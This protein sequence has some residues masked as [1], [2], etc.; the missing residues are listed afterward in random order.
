MFVGV[1]FKYL[2]IHV[3]TQAPKIKEERLFISN[4]IFFNI[5]SA[6][7]RLNIVKF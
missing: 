3:V 5:C 2:L 1:Y 4:Q 7:F 6:N